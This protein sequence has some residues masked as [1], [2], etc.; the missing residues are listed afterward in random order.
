MTATVPT[1]VSPPKRTPKP[2]P[3]NQRVS[4]LDDSAPTIFDQ[5]AISRFVR[6]SRALT[7]VVVKVGSVRTLPRTLQFFGWAK[8]LDRGADRGQ[9]FVGQLLTASQG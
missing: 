5:R 9:R 2:T 7:R 8:V 3:L 6:T 1:A 4:G